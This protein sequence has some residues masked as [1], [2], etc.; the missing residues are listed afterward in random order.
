MQRHFRA[1]KYSP[2]AMIIFSSS[3][4]LASMEKMVF[5]SLQVEVV[6]SPAA[7]GVLATPRS[8]LLTWKDLRFNRSKSSWVRVRRPLNLAKKKVRKM[9]EKISNIK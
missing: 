4:L 5:L 6:L 7:S 9:F 8:D 2:F 3:V 1:K